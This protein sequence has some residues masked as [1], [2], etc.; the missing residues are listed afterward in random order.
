MWT[1][2]LRLGL[3]TLLTF[4][5]GFGQTAT[6]VQSFPLSQASGLVMA[7]KV[8]AEEVAYQGRKAVRLVCDGSEDCLAL[9][10]GTDF[11]DGVIE[12]DIA[13]KVSTPPGFRNP[14]FIGIAFRARADASHY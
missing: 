9:L 12:A 14:G 6:S 10:P 11:Q 2:F 13:L 8:K 3:G 4:A 1:N 5:A 7:G